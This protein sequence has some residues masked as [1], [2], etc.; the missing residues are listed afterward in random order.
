MFVPQPTELAFLAVDV[1]HDT[2]GVIYT[3]VYAETY[4]TWHEEADC[5]FGTHEN[6]AT[7]TQETNAYDVGG[8]GTCDIGSDVNKAYSIFVRENEFSSTPGVALH[9]P[10]E[11][12]S[13]STTYDISRKWNTVTVSGAI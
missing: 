5:G 4:P 13:G 1:G 12:V 6:G 3:Q 10:F 7:W 2:S 9:L 11:G 8:N